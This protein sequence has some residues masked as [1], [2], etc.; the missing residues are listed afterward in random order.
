MNTLQ[1][2][3]LFS[4][5]QGEGPY[6]G[7][8]QLFLRLAGCNAAC[9]FCDTSESRSVPATCMLEQ[10]PGQR[11]F[12]VLP[13]PVPIDALAHRVNHLSQ[14]G[15]HSV[16]ITGGEPLCQSEALLQLLPL[17][18]GRI[19][20]ETNGTLPGEL[21][22]VLPYIDIVSM[23]IKLPSTSGREYWLEHRRFLTLAS[24][25]EVF[26]KIV[27]SSLTGKKEFLEALHLINSVDVKIPLIL[28][29]VTHAALAVKTERVVKLQELALEHLPDV[30]VIPQTHKYLGVL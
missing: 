2:I 1:L 12:T 23:D 8:R 17:L 22:K 20:L 28:Q 6:I 15:H 30:R 24:Q 10:T 3:E 13:N 16:S 21:V 29:P 11:D 26:V 25:K 9:I 14:A 18:Q 7:Y 19:Y 4:S 27:V 5:I